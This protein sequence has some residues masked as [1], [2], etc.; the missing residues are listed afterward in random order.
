[1]TPRALKERSAC[2]VA[3]PTTCFHPK[4]DS[5]S[6]TIAAMRVM[7]SY[8]LIDLKNT[9]FDEVDA[10]IHRSLMTYT[11][12]KPYYRD[13][14]PLRKKVEDYRS[15]ISASLSLKKAASMCCNPN[16]VQKE[17]AIHSKQVEFA[18]SHLAI[19][20]ADLDVSTEKQK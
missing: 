6:I 13:P 8:Y 16:D 1:M 11:G 2:V 4:P 12:I 10:K 17:K 14:N 9:N 7:G 18:R 5:Q 20:C 19:F 15:I 3:A